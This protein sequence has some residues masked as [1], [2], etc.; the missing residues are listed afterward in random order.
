MVSWNAC[1][2]GLQQCNAV[3]DL[4]AKE[5][6]T[7]LCIQEFCRP[8]SS[9]EITASDQ[10]DMGACRLYTSH[11]NAVHPNRPVMMIAVHK[12]F[13]PSLVAIRRGQWSLLLTFC[14]R[15]L[16]S[17]RV[18]KVHVLCSH[19]LHSRDNEEVFYFA[20]EEMAMLLFHEAKIDAHDLLL[21][22]MEANVQFP[23]LQCNFA[24]AQM[25]LKPR[26]VSA[27]MKCAIDKPYTITGPCTQGE[28]TVRSA[29]LI[30]IL[31]QANVMVA[32]TWTSLPHTWR[33]WSGN[34]EKTC[35]CH[36]WDSFGIFFWF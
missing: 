17:D 26:D 22:G 3:L 6:I 18:R 35:G 29:W 15:T 10:M 24:S 11:R 23:P 32:S 9:K 5:F 14:F 4:A 21:L 12:Q 16:Y 33:A 8:T 27:T 30:E 36:I 1:H 28:P 7:V 19:L 25:G 31:A 20:C 2:L 34:K 13:L